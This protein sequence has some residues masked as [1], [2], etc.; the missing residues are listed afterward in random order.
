M[1]EAIIIFLVV[2]ALLRHWRL[3]LILAVLYAAAHG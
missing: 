2:W 1:I 3:V